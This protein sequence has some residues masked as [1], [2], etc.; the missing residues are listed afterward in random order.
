MSRPNATNGAVAQLIEAADNGDDEAILALERIVADPSDPYSISWQRAALNFAFVTD[1]APMQ[2]VILGVWDAEP[3]LRPFL[4]QVCARAGYRG[5]ID[6]L[7]ELVAMPPHGPAASMAC[8]ALADLGAVEAVHQILPLLTSTWH[9][10]AEDAAHSL[11]R[12][13]GQEAADALWEALRTTPHTSHTLSHLATAL[14]D[15]DPCQA[16]ALLAATYDGD[17]VVR[18]WAVRALGAGRDPRSPERLTEL[19]TDGG[20]IPTGSTVGSAARRGL[21]AWERV[22]TRHLAAP[23]S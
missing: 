6:R 2:D 15:I 17:P 11:G 1:P 20:L 16:D 23:H 21:R 9:G 13:G 19:L 22:S 7:V 3:G 10:V 4:T 18:Y 8:T 14:A 5:A 12:L